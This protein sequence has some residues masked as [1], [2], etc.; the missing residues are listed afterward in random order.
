MKKFLIVFGLIIF[1]TVPAFAACD[2]TS[3]CAPKPY[4]ISSKGCQV[5]SNITGMTFLTEKIAQSIIK[6]ELKKETKAKFKV[7]MK[8][9]SARDL[10]AGRFKSLKI[11]GKNLDVEGVYLSSFETKTLCDFNYVELTKK[12]IKFKEN[13]VMDF[14]IEISNNDLQKTVKSADYLKMLNSINLSGFGIT[15]FRLSEANVQ[16]KNN[17][18]YFTINVTSPMSTKPLPIVVRSD[19]KIEDGN[20]VLTKIDLVNLY[21]VIDLSK[22]T[23]ILN[24]I[25]PLNFSMEILENQKSKIQVQTV[26]IKG[27]RIFI[28]GNVFIPKNTIK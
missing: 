7:E 21:T 6:K 20:I 28:N 13:M 16:I 17:K 24:A 4:D 19:V 12:S 14:A 11:S 25:N 18:L 23:Y 2:Y 22:M 3:L 26:E 15:F 1:C 27:D 10:L 5:T 9:Y 8:S